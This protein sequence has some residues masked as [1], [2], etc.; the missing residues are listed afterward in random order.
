MRD[1]AIK[2]LGAVSVAVSVFMAS[3]WSFFKMT[4]RCKEQKRLIKKKWFQLSHIKVNHPRHKFEK[5]YEDGKAWCMQQNMQDCYLS[6]RDGLMLHAYYLPARNAKRFVLLSHGYKGSGF[7]DFAY[8]SRFLHENHCNLLFIDQRC[9]GASKGEYITFGAMEQYDIKKWAY[10]ISKRNYKKL[11]IYLYGE[12]MGAAS[13]LMAS[14]NKLPDEVRGLIS[15]CGF[16]SMK[17]QVQ[18][19]AANWFHLHWVGLLLFRLDLFCR[20]LAG[21]RMKDADTTR[22]LERNKRPIL[23]F[24]G[25]EDTY[26]DQ[27]NSRYNYAVCRAPKELVV[28]PEARH[29]CSAYVEPKLYRKKVLEFFAK[30]D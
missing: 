6:S 26:V 18:D 1:K 29:L 21:F 2:I 20:I 8:T 27:R 15:D 23:F 5:E 4:V 14:G 25:A 7:G 17:G 11:P 30:Y 13:V 19:M 22:A 24:H 12:S 10:Y 3:G 16:R 28:I 9:C